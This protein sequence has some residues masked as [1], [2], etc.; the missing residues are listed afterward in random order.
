MGERHVLR[1]ITWT[2]REGEHWALMGLNG[3]G[4]TTVLNLITGYVF[5]SAGRLSVFGKRFGEHDWRRVR[6]S[7]GFIS[8]SL[9]ERFSG[10]ETALEIVLSGMYG[11]IGLYDR[12]GKKERER[13]LSLLDEFGCVTAARQQYAE[14]S[15]GEKQ[16]VLIA[17]ALMSSP[18]LLIMDEPCAGL[19]MFARE[20]LLTV[21][22]AMAGK[23]SSPSLLYVT[24][25]SEEILPLFTHALLL[26]QGMVHSAGST[27]K[28]LTERTLSSFFN[29]PVSVHRKQSRIWVTL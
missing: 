28:V 14:L 23:K 26:R 19:D 18:R 16:K 5:P 11:S 7:I 29:S 9:Q 2:F 22:G 17:R 3:S 20:K 12:P 1:D 13:A 21:I 4:K 24:H 8:S 15:Q 6:R 27:G 25:H 10:G